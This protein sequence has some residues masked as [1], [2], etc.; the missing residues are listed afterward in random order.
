LV[1][2]NSGGVMP[3]IVITAQV[4]D[5]AIWEKGFRTHEDLFRSAL[6]SG[7]NYY[8]TDGENMVAVYTEVDDLSKYMEML[9]S[10]ATADAMTSDGVKRETVKV[11]VLGKD[12]KF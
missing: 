10:D 12:L 1:L 4:Q 9:K 8:G 11:F 7:S 5:Y 2:S 6:G 3:R